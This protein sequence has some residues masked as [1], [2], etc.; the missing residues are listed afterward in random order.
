MRANVRIQNVDQ[1]L[2]DLVAKL[3][4]EQGDDLRTFELYF[5]MVQKI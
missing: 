5:I 1:E 4:D 3:Y 2:T